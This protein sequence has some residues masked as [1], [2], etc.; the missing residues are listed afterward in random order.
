MTQICRD[1]TRRGR[2]QYRQMARPRV[3]TVM[4]GLLSASFAALACAYV[5]YAL[6]PLNNN[7]GA[8]GVV[9]SLVVF[10]L[11][12]VVLGWLALRSRRA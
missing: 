12:A 4:L 6:D 2:G 3:A 5:V 9:L 10:G 11:P 7:G 8:F 1:A